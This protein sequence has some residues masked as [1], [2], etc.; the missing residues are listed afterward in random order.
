LLIIGLTACFPEYAG[1]GQTVAVVGD[2]ITA[3]SAKE[4]ATALAPY[5]RSVVGVPS[6]AMPEALGR[7]VKPAVSTDPAV[8]VVELGLND[9]L[10]GWD[11]SDLPALEATLKALDPADCV[12]WITPTALSPSYYDH[13]G[14]GTMQAR[15]NAFKA[16][17][18][19]RLPKHPNVHLADPSAD[20]LAHPE[21]Y[22][23]DRM[24]HSPAGRTAYAAFVAEAVEICS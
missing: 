1:A 15:A 4:I 7:L 9:A 23:A 18:K 20:Q 21:W 3:H 16:S 11:S 8:L 12:V 24:H 5:R 6:I 19:K 17:L 2:S 13:L 22:D 14:P 10:D